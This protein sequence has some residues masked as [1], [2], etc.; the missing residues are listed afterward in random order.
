MTGAQ[1]GRI[2]L[3]AAAAAAGDDSAPFQFTYDGAEYELPPQ[4]S[5]PVK[6]IRQLGRGDLEEALTSLLG[7][8]AFIG[9]ADAGMTL[10]EMNKLFE[11]AAEAAGVGDLPNSSRRRRPAPTRT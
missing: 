5:W 9:L 2:D 3:K 1:N 8:K 6:A 10:G 7:E 11:L 4:T